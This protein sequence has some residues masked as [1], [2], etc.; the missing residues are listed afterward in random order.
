MMT[1][2]EQFEDTDCGSFYDCCDCG[3]R[4]SDFQSCMRCFS[5]NAC[6]VCFDDRG[7]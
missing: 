7:E 6:D 1:D 5:C 4:D 3:Q 2:C